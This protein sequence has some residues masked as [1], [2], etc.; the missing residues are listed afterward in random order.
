MIHHDNAVTRLC[1]AVTRI[2]A[3]TWPIRRTATVE[4]FLEELADAY[5]VDLAT[6]DVEDL[7]NR[8]G[9]LGYLV[10]ATLQNTAN[11]TM[12]EAGYKH[13]VIPAE[14]VAS[15]DGRVLPGFE[16][17]FDETIRALVGE[18]I[19]LEMVNSDVAIESPF[20][21]ATVDLM[22]SVL[23]AEDPGARP[24][25]YMISGGT[26]AKAFVRLGIDCYGFSPL[27]MPADVDY[28][29]LFHGKDER[30]PVDGLQFGVRVLDRFLRAV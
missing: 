29:R 11:P 7:L 5:G 25:P 22:A 9:T 1:E 15:I 13:N 3:H 24:V 19:D 20:D 28:W 26:D 8:L 16:A 4:R 18:G 12:L 21:T 23:R 14:A 2:G 6:T 30:V 10:G 27:R 17:E